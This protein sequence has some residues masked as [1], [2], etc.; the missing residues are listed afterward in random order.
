LVFV[1]ATVFFGDWTLGLSHSQRSKL[2]LRGKRSHSSAKD[3]IP[4]GLTWVIVFPTRLQK[5]L[6]NPFSSKGTISGRQI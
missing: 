5:Q 6:A 2:L 3:G 1:S 4:Q